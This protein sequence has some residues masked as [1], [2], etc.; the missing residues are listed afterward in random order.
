MAASNRTLGVRRRTGRKGEEETGKVWGTEENGPVRA[1]SGTPKEE[2][3]WDGEERKWD[4]EEVG[5][6]IR[7]Y[8][9][10]RGTVKEE[11]R[12]RG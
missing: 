9:G 3:K 10:D 4:G 7:A 2:R 1:R 12:G 11:R 8:R 6:G 5:R